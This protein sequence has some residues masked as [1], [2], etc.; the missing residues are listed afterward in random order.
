M[1][2]GF[3][4]HENV[5]T[6]NTDTVDGNFNDF[7]FYWIN[8]NEQLFTLYYTNRLGWVDMTNYNV[9]V[10]VDSATGTVYSIPASAVTTS[11]H[12]VTFTIPRTNVPLQGEYKMEIQA[13]TDNTNATKTLAQGKASVS[14]SL[15]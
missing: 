2:Y 15:Y 14:K 13:Y 12:I 1:V 4:S 5:H 11:T 9:K 8:G 3:P 10:A 7:H 6:N